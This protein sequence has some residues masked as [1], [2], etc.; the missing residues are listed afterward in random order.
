MEQKMKKTKVLTVIA[1][2]LALVA[3]LGCCGKVQSE[4]LSAE[5]AGAYSDFI[6]NSHFYSDDKVDAFGAIADI[7]ADGKDEL[8]LEVYA[9]SVAVFAYN[10]ISK[11]TVELY[12]QKLGKGYNMQ[13]YYN[14][15][16]HQ[17]IFPS[18][19]TGGKTY[20]VIEFSGSKADAVKTLRYINAKHSESGAAEYLVDGQTVTAKEFENTEKSLAEGFTGVDI[21]VTEI[22]SILDGAA[23]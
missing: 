2:V 13:G 22:I 3:V 11:E 8:I 10:E 5:A 23:G 12:S 14:T 19:S 9:S 21:S 1:V 17:V 7:N 15:E 20:D 16:K 4:S 18:A 6:R